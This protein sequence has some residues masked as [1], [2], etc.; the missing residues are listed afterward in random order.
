MKK[1]LFLSIVIM[2]IAACTAKKTEVKETGLETYLY[3]H[4]PMPMDTAQSLK[5]QWAQKEVLAS[6]IIDDMESLKNWGLD[7][8][9]TGKNFATISLSKEKVFEGKTSVKFVCPTKQPVQLPNGGRY[10]GRE[11][12]TRKFNTEDLSKYNRIS[13]EVFPVFKGFRQ[14]YL[15]VILH[16]DANVP[17]KYGKSGWHTVQLKNNQWNKLIMEIPHLP[18]DQVNAISISYGLQGNEPDAADTII[19]YAD[20]LM[21]E[22]VKT[23]YFEGWG[24]DEAISFC[25]AGYS[26]NSKKTA[27][28]S[29]NSGDKFKL[30][31]LATSNTVLEKD[32]LKQSSYIGGF[33]VF[34]FSEFKTPGNYKIVYGKV[35]TKPFPISE[36][37]W[38]PT[39][40]KT[41]NLLFNLRCGFE[42]PGIHLKC[43]TDWYTV[44]KGDTIEMSGGWHDAGDLSQSYART[45]ETAGIL[46]KLARRYQKTDEQLANRLIEEGMWGLKWIHKNRFDGLQ[47]LGWTTH[48]HY[49]DGKIGN[50]DD[51]PT[52]LGNRGGGGGGTDNY[53]SVI[54]NVEASMTLKTIDP[55]F[56]EKTKQFAVDDWG[57]LS[58]DTRRFGTERLSMA[59]LAGSKLYQLTGSKD[60]K[61]QIIS[62]ADTLLTYQ[63]VEPMKWSVPLSGFFY[64]NKAQERIFGYAAGFTVASP[65]TG[66]VELCKLFPGDK[67]YKLWYNS[68]KLYGNYLKTI[69][70]YTAPYY[71]IPANVYKTGTAEDAQILN[72]VKMDDSH[73]LRMFPVWTQHRGNN[74]NVLSFGVGLAAANQILKDPEM[75][76]IALAQLEWVVGKN[77]FNQ[78]LMYGEGYNF[79]TQY[80]AFPGD[81]TGG[82]PVGI[83]TKLDSDIPF[84]PAAVLHN[85]KEIWIHPS[86]RWLVLLDY[87][88]L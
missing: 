20:K 75:R 7:K 29:L 30:V 78:S 84:Q 43:H 40:E 12:L 3:N 81:V 21:L 6:V 63:Q 35:E 22:T 52:L 71:M 61:A 77:P 25:H 79:S 24:T 23:D 15:T 74:A 1:L 37:V 28:T 18:H 42:V 4:V 5:Y 66:L 41:V 64:V 73:Y 53:Y 16:N 58:K 19:F 72:G 68:V 39:L 14:L 13:V 80:A 31:D 2:L 10:W 11:N 38:L 50:F 67:K 86:S 17:D 87:L 65:I 27:F 36:D 51:T 57:L 46:F 44:Y 69:S 85:Y 26:E 32:A 45:A 54:A 59:I 34:D 83:E 88:N 55:A 47:V 62:Y 82:L 33:N 48:D 60:I 70:Q 9:R 56:S 76:S 49:S 8:P